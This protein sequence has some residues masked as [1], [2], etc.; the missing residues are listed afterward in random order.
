MKLKINLNADVAEGYGKWKMGNDKDIL[1]QVNSANI[2]C[3]KHAGDENIMFNTVKLC[4]KNN[5]DIGVHPGFSDIEGF[6]RRRLDISENNIE[7]LIAYQTGALVGIA[8]MLNAK[9]THMK[10][11]GALNNIACEDINVAKA[12]IRGFKTIDKNLI[13]LAPTY[14]ELIKAGE[15]Y[16]IKC[17]EE[18]FAD[19]AYMSDGSLSSR[20]L[21]DSVITNIE[22]AVN[23][24]IEIAKGEKIK[25]LDGKRIYL[26][27]KS[28]CIHGDKEEALNQAKAIKKGLIENS[29]ELVNLNQI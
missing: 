11:H 18:G 25:T 26:P 13:L 20:S 22:T 12:I 5:I 2:A 6:G 3:G 10:P 27:A 8:S 29:F 17:I 4:N 1:N 15:H 24:A 19:R 23:Q 7:N 16:G 21:K 9:V 14:S 28:I